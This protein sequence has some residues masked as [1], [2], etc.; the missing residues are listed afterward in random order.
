[1]Y[2]ESNFICQRRVIGVITSNQLSM[3][4]NIRDIK[5]EDILIVTAKLH[6]VGVKGNMAVEILW[7]VYIKPVKVTESQASRLHCLSFD[8]FYK[9]QTGSLYCFVVMFASYQCLVRYHRQDKR[10][11][12][13][14]HLYKTV[15]L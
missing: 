8:K 10:Q 3:F 6:T 15:I 4:Y 14:K 13:Q 11:W 7:T 5:F 2:K 9:S 1:M 12:T